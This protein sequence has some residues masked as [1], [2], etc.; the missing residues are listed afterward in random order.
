MPTNGQCVVKIDNRHSQQG[1]QRRIVTS[2]HSQCYS[3]V[4]QHSQ[5]RFTN[6]AILRALYRFRDQLRI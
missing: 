5:P 2:H 1:Q 4:Y 6:P 3:E